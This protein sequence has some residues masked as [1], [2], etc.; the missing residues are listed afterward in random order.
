VDRELG[1]LRPQGSVLG[2][3]GFYRNSDH[4]EAFDE[5]NGPTGCVL[6]DIWSIET[7]NN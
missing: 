4:R 5:Y 7:W 3:V 2:E 1:F 6:D